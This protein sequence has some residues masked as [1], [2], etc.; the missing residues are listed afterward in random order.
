MDLQ[1]HYNSMYDNAVRRFK[2]S[3]CEPDAWID[4]A[5]DSRMGLTLRLRPDRQV[6]NR[7][8]HF[9]NAARELEPN[10]YFYG[11]ENIHVTVLS[12][13]SCYPGFSVSDIVVADYVK[14]INES[15]VGIG[16]FNLT[17]RGITASPSCIMVQ[18]FMEDDALEVLRQRL[19]VNIAKS[20]L[21]ESMDKRYTLQTA[22]ATVLRLKQK[23][24]NRD[25]LLQ[26]LDKYR[27]ND[28]G[29]SSVSE[30]ELVLNDWYH[31]PDRTSVL[32]RIP[33]LE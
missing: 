11:E 6:V 22:H 26:L 17:F 14:A 23:M 30:V 18:G 31:Q 20:G 1:E 3:A 25:G 16:P 10:Q 28:W 8:Q 5:G 21:E 2:E 4:A 29:C 32:K 9:L 13:I 19:R 24:E 12:I 27:N 7:I 33:L 15:L